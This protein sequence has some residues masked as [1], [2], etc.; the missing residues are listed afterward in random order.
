M[1]KHTADDLRYVQRVHEFASRL[2]GEFL[3]GSS[4]IEVI[5]TAILAQYFCPDIKRRMLFFSEVANGMRLTSKIA[6]LEKV[7][8]RD[9]PEF[10]KAHPRL[11]KRLEKFRD[12]RNVLAHSHID[13]SERAL[14]KKRANEVTFVF[15][16]LGELAHRRVTA[17][18]ATQRANE[19]NKVR[20]ELIELQKLVSDAPESVS[21]GP[22]TGND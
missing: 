18:E 22:P 16:K 14:R 21:G 11:T 15:Y 12:F 8:L 5:L 13:T 2:R 7:I 9:F 10:A 20:A 6:L 3:T 1:S 19:A 4:W 17:A